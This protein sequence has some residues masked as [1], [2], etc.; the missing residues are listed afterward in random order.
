[1]VI[2]PASVQSC[3]LLCISSKSHQPTPK[4]TGV[5]WFKDD[6]NTIRGAILGDVPAYLDGFSAAEFNRVESGLLAGD[7]EYE[8]DRES[9]RRDQDLDVAVNSQLGRRIHSGP[10]V[11]ELVAHGPKRLAA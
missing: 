10:I 9:F 11:A 2:G 1:M 3:S 7:H 5:A 4:G 8:M 6:R